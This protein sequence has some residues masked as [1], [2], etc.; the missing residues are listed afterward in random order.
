ML[1]AII[2]T[3]CFFLFVILYCKSMV[4]IENDLD[5][6]R[7]EKENKPYMA[8]DEYDYGHNVNYTPIDEEY[9]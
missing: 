5:K 4:K 6:M 2:F 9:L 1:T 7:E 8:N 3:I